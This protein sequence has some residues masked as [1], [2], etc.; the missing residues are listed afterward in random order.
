MVDALQSVGF[1]RQSA[2]KLSSAT[3][4]CLTA[5][6]EPE[7]AAKSKQRAKRGSNVPLN[8]LWVDHF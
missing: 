4:V 1:L 5:D 8:S 7:S 3:H 6:T 2:D